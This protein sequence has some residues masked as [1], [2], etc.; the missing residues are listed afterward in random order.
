M[1]KQDEEVGLILS[2]QEI[3]I[4]VARTPRTSGASIRADSYVVRDDRIDDDYDSECKLLSIFVSHHTHTHARAQQQ[5]SAV[6]LSVA[7]CGVHRIMIMVSMMVS[8]RVVAAVRFDA[9]TC[10]RRCV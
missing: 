1:K 2:P 4:P 9:F 8:V 10:P 7:V 3:E 6:N 5:V